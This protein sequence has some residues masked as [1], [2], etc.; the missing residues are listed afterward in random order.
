[1]VFLLGDVVY[2]GQDKQTRY[3]I[4]RIHAHMNTAFEYDGIS[5][6]GSSFSFALETE[7]TKATDQVI[8]SAEQA[9]NRAMAGI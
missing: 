5:L 9:Y 3:V 8:D 4:T 7:L 2:Y 6:G 1:M